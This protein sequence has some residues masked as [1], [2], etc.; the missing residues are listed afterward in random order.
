MSFMDDTAVEAALAPDTFDVL[1]FVENTAYPVEH[2][3]LFTDI[4]AAREYT[5]LSAQ[6][7]EREDAETD[8]EADEIE[9]KLA[10]LAAKLKATSLTFELRGFP[11]GIVDRI[12]KEHATEENPAGADNELVA[13][14]IISVTNGSGAKDARLWDAE[15]VARLKD[16][17]AE[18]EFLKLLGAVA[19]VI[20]NAAVFKQATD[21]GFPG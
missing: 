21:A 20:F 5:E 4:T 17:V 13:K 3:T 8:A 16:N 15:M 9:D 18:G 11:P 7:Q 1:A 12:M 2:V 19:N 10:A 6:R 14:A